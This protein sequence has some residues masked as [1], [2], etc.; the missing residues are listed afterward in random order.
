MQHRIGSSCS[1]VSVFV[2]AVLLAGCSGPSITAVRLSPGPKEPEGIPYYL[3]KPYLFVTKNFYYIPAPTVG[4]TAVVPIPGSFDTSGSGNGQSTKPSTNSTPT[5]KTQ[6]QQG[7]GG[8][9]TPTQGSSQPSSTQGNSQPAPT[10]TANRY[11]LAA[12]DPPDVDALPNA[13]FDNNGVLRLISDTAPPPAQQPPAQNVQ[14]P[15]GGQQSPDNNNTDTT[16]KNK[17]GDN[18]NTVSGS[19][20]TQYGGQVPWVFPG[21]NTMIPA[22]V[23]DGL[24]P[25]EYFTYQIVYLPDLTQKYGLRIHGGHG[26]LRATENLVNGWMHTGPGPFYMKN[27]TSAETESAAFQGTASLLDSVAK[28]VVS[29]LVPS[30]AAANVAGSAV[31]SALKGVATSGETGNTNLGGVI[32][33]YAILYVYEPVLNTNNNTVS[34]QA[35]LTNYF[36][37]EVIAVA[38]APGQEQSTP[39]VYAGLEKT[40]SDAIIAANPTMNFTG[41]KVT[42]NP[43]VGNNQTVKVVGQAANKNGTAVSDDNLKTLKT[44]I[45]K[46]V[47]DACTQNGNKVT[48]NGVDVSGIT[49][50]AP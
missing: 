50:A 3:P 36:D 38:S 44:A 4:L 22:L 32:T 18:T 2:L 40:I 19:A 27:S 8:Q 29:G 28:G 49:A 5:T 34:W 48:T 25:Q 43:P 9:P 26:E 42:V 13:T 6:K 33:N 17:G 46:T 21:T 23:P 1:V 15:Q 16:G 7:G 10:Q 14:Q 37:R 31:S 45:Q 30:S 11:L 39:D 24:I 12:N 35:I 47:V 41:L 20:T